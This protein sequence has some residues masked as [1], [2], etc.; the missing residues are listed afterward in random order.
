MLGE[1][2]IDLGGEVIFGRDLLFGK[3]EFSDV[4]VCEDTCVRKGIEGVEKPFYVSVY[5]YGADTRLWGRTGQVPL[6]RRGRRHR[7]HVSDAER[8][9]QPL[10]VGEEEGTVLLD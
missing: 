2:A 7:I 5:R 9:A 10:V 3:D 1:F 8:L 4:A 6:P